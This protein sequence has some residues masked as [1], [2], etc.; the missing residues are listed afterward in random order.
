M[1]HQQAFRFWHI[2]PLVTRAA[3]ARLATRM[4]DFAFARAVANDSV[5]AAVHAGINRCTGGG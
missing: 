2:G 4:D 5:L 1:L 3:V